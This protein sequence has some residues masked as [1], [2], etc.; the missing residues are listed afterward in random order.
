M[1]KLI[2][3]SADSRQLLHFGFAAAVDISG[4]RV[5][6]VYCASYGSS[7][8]EEL[9]MAAAPFSFLLLRRQRKGQVNFTVVYKNRVET[10]VSPL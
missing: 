2:S 1:V 8:G 6:Y 3:C 9:K 7:E 10:V 4:G 5:V